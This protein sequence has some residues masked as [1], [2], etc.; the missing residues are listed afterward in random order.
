MKPQ[1]PLQVLQ[2]VKTEEKKKQLLEANKAAARALLSSIS[3]V[4]YVTPKKNV[5]NEL[6]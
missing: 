1:I 5:S 3:T 6:S 2:V 4:S